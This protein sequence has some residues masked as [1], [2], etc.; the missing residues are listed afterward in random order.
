MGGSVLL[1]AEDPGA[2]NY[3]APIARALSV[4][5][6]AARLCAT[7]AA[8]RY[9]AERGLPAQT[10]AAGAAAMAMVAEMRPRL[11][12]V[13]T[14][15]NKKTAAFDLIAAAKSV[16]AKSLGVVDCSTNA[17]FR[18]RG[19]ADDPLAHAPEELLVPDRQ[20]FKAFRG[21]GL[22][23]A[24]LHLCGHPHYDVVRERKRA[25]D[26]E[27]RATV[28]ARELPGVSAN[29][30]AIVFLAELSTGFTETHFQLAPDYTLRGR[31][32]RTGR[33]EIV[34]EEFLDAVSRFPGPRPHLVLR[35]HPKNTR[36][37]FG[38]L[39]D[40]FDAVSTGS[41]PLALVYAADLV[42]GMTSMLMIEAALFLRPTLAILPRRTE[43]D[44]LPTIGAGI[45][46]P[47]YTSAEIYAGLT[48]PVP[49]EAE[50]AARV[51][52]FFPPDSISRV[53]EVVRRA[54][55]D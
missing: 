12:I 11:V 33:T 8:L 42:V 52:A 24:R 44:W 23:A 7:G 26:A 54:L 50:L 51:E 27:G 55:A 14:S 13:G 53:M 49:H 37:E 29:R 34:M 35:L 1:F 21:F 40:A 17:E 46:R 28:C 2:A 5:G 43:A 19:T 10:V 47:A 15:E 31:G 36:E 16:G 18:F 41:S 6:I 22:P 39:A 4:E 30:R 25:L 9:F 3:I 32:R 48:A 20:T 38:A 45:T